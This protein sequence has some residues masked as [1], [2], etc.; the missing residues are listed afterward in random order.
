MTNKLPQDCTKAQ[1]VKEPAEK[2]VDGAEVVLDSNKTAQSRLLRG[3]LISLAGGA[4]WGINGT[5]VKILLEVYN[6]PELWLV[7]IRELGAS[8]LFLAT[9]YVVNRSGLTGILKNKR[10]MLNLTWISVASILMSNISYVMTISYTNSATATVLQTLSVVMVLF[11]VCVHNRRQP[12]RRELIGIVLAIGGTYLLATGGNPSELAIPA[13]GLAWGGMCALSAAALAILPNDLLNKWGS[14]VVNG[15]A[16]LI[17]GLMLALYVQPW[18]YLPNIDAVGWILII[19]AIVVGT[20]GAYALFLQG[21]REVG[22]V[23]ASMLT[24]SEPLVAM[25]SSVLLMGTAFSVTDLIA[26]A[27][28]IV[29]VYLTA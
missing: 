6:I 11:Y 12:R 2:T 29:M 9:A 3:V 28:I 26:F 7:C 20:Y 5:F 14:F 15:Y 22:A 23:R 25:I 1:A 16:M 4:C 21:L 17:S 10:D 13:L 24:T 19:F 27:M 18:N 8:V